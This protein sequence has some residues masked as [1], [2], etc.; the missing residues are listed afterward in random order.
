VRRNVI[1]EDSDPQQASGTLPHEDNPGDQA[2]H[3]VAGN[4]G[5]IGV[6]TVLSLA[7]SSPAPTSSCA[8]AWKIA[9]II[10]YVDPLPIPLKMNSTTKPRM[11]NGSESI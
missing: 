2:A 10:L 7:R 6:I 8:F 9:G 1:K 3:E 11:N 5:E 4:E